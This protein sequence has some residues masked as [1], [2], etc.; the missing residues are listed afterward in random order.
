MGLGDLRIIL[1]RNSQ[2]NSGKR[3]IWSIFTSPQR[4]Q[5][6]R[7]P[8]LRCGLVSVR[9]F[10]AL[11]PSSSNQ[12]QGLV[13]LAV[14]PKLLGNY[15]S[16]SSGGWTMPEWGR[17]RIYDDITQTHRQ[18][19]ADPLAARGRRRQG[20]RG[21]Q[22]GKLQSALVGQGPHRRGHDRRRRAR[23]QDQQG[24]RHHRADQRQ[25]R[26]RPG[27]HLC[28]PRLQADRHHARKHE[29]RT[30]PAAQGLRGRD[31]ADPGREGHERRHRQGRRNWW[32]RTPNAFMPQQFENPANPEIHR[33]TTAEEIWNDTEGKVDIL[34]SGVGTGGTITGVSEVHQEA[35]A[36]VQGDRGGAGDQ[37]GHH[38]EDAGRGH[39]IRSS[40]AGTASRASAP[41]SFR[42]CSTSTSS[43]R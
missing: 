29:P 43:T 8:C 41:A 15:L 10:T 22:A 25:H 42:A 33:K 2:T 40:R 13:S 9:R 37:P 16:R 14:S 11:T 3:T 6:I 26:H 21:R 1:L 30:P 35:Q 7:I 36:V 5:G 28:G 19:A 34:V 4:K 18:H 38:A 17:G 39:A 23:R 27:V 24:H 32:P 20:D 12:L 31:R